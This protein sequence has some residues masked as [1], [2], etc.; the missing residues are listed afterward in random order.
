M[1]RVF[2]PIEH[3]ALP[4]DDG[5]PKLGYLE[6]GKQS[7]DRKKIAVSNFIQTYVGR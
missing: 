2:T 1:D 4:I 6:Q 5:G 3:A 7:S